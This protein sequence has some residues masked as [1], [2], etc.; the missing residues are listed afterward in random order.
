MQCGLRAVPADAN[1]VVFTPVD[2]PNI[3][4]ATVELP[5]RNRRVSSWPSFDPLG[6]V[7]VVSRREPEAQAALAD[8]LRLHVVHQ[9]EHLAEVVAGD[10]LRG[11][12][13]LEGSLGR[14]AL[15][16]VKR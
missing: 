2:H 12:A 4:P 10:L 14:R 1:G 8:L 6:D 11:L 5:A 16:P 15:G 9:A 7:A 13:D 3:E